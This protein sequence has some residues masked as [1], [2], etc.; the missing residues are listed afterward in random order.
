MPLRIVGVVSWQ[1]GLLS[2]LG[3][4][5]L[6]QLP[7]P[8]DMTIFLQFGALGVLAFAV[9]GLFRELAE[10]RR[11]AKSERDAHAK[12]IENMCTRQD[13][14]DKARHDDHEALQT[15]LRTMSSQCAATQAKLMADASK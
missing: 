15:T 14:W 9:V 10:Q 6:A 11:N 12:I 4:E 3:L 7:L 8:A 5:A 1:A 13:G 2:W